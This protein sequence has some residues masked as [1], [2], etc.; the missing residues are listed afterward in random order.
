MNDGTGSTVVV[1]KMSREEALRLF[2]LDEG[3]SREELDKIY[4]TAALKHLNMTKQNIATAEDDAEMDRMTEAL[5]VLTGRRTKEEREASKN[6][7]W[8][9]GFRFESLKNYFYVFGWQTALIL[10]AVLVVGWFA[11]DITHKEVY[12]F[13]VMTMGTVSIDG[14]KLAELSM[15]LNPDI[16]NPSIKGSHNSGETEEEKEMNSNQRYDDEMFASIY[17]VGNVDLAI[18]DKN[19]YE[20]LSRTGYFEDL[21]RYVND[22]KTADGQKNKKDIK[23]YR[24]RFP[25]NNGY[26]DGIDVA[27]MS[28]VKGII[29]GEHC[30]A[31]HR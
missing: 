10:A 15:Q 8:W 7:G 5:N 11:Y 24:S 29:N 28:K 6:N 18:M 22:H 16:K 31:W 2:G 25:D 9:V 19:T 12:D 3:F 17:V 23:G 1:D 14:E 4:E 13:N 21:S 20:R 27:G 30:S 26:I